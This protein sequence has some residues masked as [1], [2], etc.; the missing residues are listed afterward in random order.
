[1]RF[2][3]RAT[4]TAGLLSCAF[5]SPALATDNGHDYNGPLGTADISDCVYPKSRTGAFTF[6]F[7]ASP[8]VTFTSKELGKAAR[9]PG[10]EHAPGSIRVLRLQALTIGGR[11]TYL[12]RGGTEERGVY[13]GKAHAHIAASDLQ[14]P[15]K[16]ASHKERAGLGRATPGCTFPIYARP[17]ELPA[18]MKY[19]PGEPATSGAMWAN[20]GDPG[21]RFGTSY[22]NLLW[23]LPRRDVGGN[24]S[25]VKGGGILM[26]TIKPRQRLLVCDVSHQVLDSFTGSRVTGYTEWVYVATSNGTETLY[27]WFMAGAVH[28]GTGYQLFDWQ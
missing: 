10:C 12:T 22:T 19:R 18:D 25:E 16:L 21:A 23:N 1:M 26:A 2:T 15:L 5:T 20:Y 17:A 6:A 4:L 24:E 7:D 28:A 9:W 27:G 14:R 8:A 13:P 11:T 3:P